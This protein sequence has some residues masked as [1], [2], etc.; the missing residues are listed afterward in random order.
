MRVISVQR[1]ER[2]RH[3]RL[4]RH[5]AD[6]AADEQFREDLVEALRSDEPSLTV[7]AQLRRRYHLERS[8]DDVD[9]R[10]SRRAVLIARLRSYDLPEV[11]S[12]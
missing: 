1:V 11:R 5:Q 9:R 4:R 6:Q 7:L 2:T 3:C 8:I 10:L 12:A